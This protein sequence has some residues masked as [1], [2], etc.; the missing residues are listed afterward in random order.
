MSEFTK[1]TENM[2]PLE[3]EAWDWII[4]LDADEPLCDREK[5]RLTEWLSRSPTHIKQLRKLN[6]FWGNA[7]LI[8]LLNITKEPVKKSTS[9]QA[10]LFTPVYRFA[11]ITLLSLFGA[12]SWWSMAPSEISDTNMIY[13]TAIGQQKTFTLA[14][15]SQ[16]FLNSD[17]QLKTSY[18]D[19]FRDIWLVKGQAHFEVMKDK[20]RP[21]NVYAA[22][23]RVQAVGTA[24]SVEVKHNNIEVLVTEGRIALAITDIKK[25]VTAE[26]NTLSTPDLTVNKFYRNSMENIAFMNAGDFINISHAF[27]ITQ[28]KVDIIKD[29]KPLS[30]PEIAAQQAW[31]EGAIVFT[32]QSLKE[33]VQDLKRYSPLHIEIAD[34]SLAELKIGGRFKVNHIDQLLKNLAVN[35]ELDVQQV[36]PD[37]VIITKRIKQQ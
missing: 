9:R 15:G 4:R 7:A 24:F 10:Q 27:N 16:V 23:S 31:L 8:E 28:D 21:F 1:F 11:F 30:I 22:N 26:N 32:G 25:Q 36:R 5:S 35:F 34:P 37:K 13:A 29:I 2:S 33:V 6:A 3:S 12:L 19:S 17:S 18:S 20:N 14:D